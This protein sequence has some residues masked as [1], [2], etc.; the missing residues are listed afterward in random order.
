M[1]IVPAYRISKETIYRYKESGAARL[2]FHK[3]L[4][5]NILFVRHPF[6]F[7]EIQLFTTLAFLYN[8]LIIIYHNTLI[9]RAF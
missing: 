5:D 9:M 6:Y 4:P 2:L 3:R 8:F 7:L 1:R